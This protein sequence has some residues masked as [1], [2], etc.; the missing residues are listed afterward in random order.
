MVVGHVVRCVVN[1]ADC[2]KVY[3]HGVYF[4]G[5]DCAVARYV[6]GVGVVGKGIVAR[7]RPRKFEA[8]VIYKIRHPRNGVAAHVKVGVGVVVKAGHVARVNIHRVARYCV[9]KGKDRRPRGIGGGTRQDSAVVGLCKP[10]AIL[11]DVHFLGGYFVVVRGHRHIRRGSGVLRGCGVGR[12]GGACKNVGYYIVVAVVAVV[13]GKVIGHVFVGKHRIRGGVAA[14]F[15][16]LVSCRG[17]VGVPG[18]GKGI[19]VYTAV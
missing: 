4:F 6:R 17:V 13:N 8:A 10:R 2:V 16:V 3:G 11:G 7:I 15:F 19:V 5:R 12:V 14:H 9:M 18:V 1:F